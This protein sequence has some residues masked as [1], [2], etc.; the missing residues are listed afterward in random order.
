MIASKT[1]RVVTAAEGTRVVEFSARRAHG[2]RR[3]YLPA[4]AAAIGGAVGSSNVLAGQ[5]F[6]VYTYGTQAHPLGDGA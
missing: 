1:A 2:G 3:G 4:R 5:Q 6:G